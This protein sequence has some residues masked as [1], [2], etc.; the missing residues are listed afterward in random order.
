[1]IPNKIFD[2]LKWFSIVA[3][4]AISTFIVDIGRI[5]NWGDIAGMVAQT[6]TA[7][8]VLLGALLGISAINYKKNEDVADEIHG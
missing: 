2:V 3:L 7:V 4:P 5:W 8:A 1:M 6:I